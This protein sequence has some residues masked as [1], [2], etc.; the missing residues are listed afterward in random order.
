MSNILYSEKVAARI[1]RPK[2][3][4][5]LRMCRFCEIGPL[6]TFDGTGAC[7]ACLPKVPCPTCGGKGEMRLIRTIQTY[8]PGRGLVDDVRMVVF[9]C[10]PC[11]GTGRKYPAGENGEYPWLGDPPKRKPGP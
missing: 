7:V 11:W 10:E 5:T 3:E 6:V 9:G 2:V 1:R 4:M 8:Q